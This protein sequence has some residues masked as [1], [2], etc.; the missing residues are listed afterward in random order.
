MHQVW[1]KVLL[2]DGSRDQ[3]ALL[4]SLLAPTVV[5]G[6]FRPSLS[7]LLREGKWRGKSCLH[8]DG[9][10]WPCNYHVCNLFEGFKH[11][12][13]HNLLAIGLGRW[14]FALQVTSFVDAF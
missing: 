11:F 13:L 4:Q 6:V 14:M 5:R 9:G 2:Q 1:R 10:L 8:Y 3:A 12:C 7:F